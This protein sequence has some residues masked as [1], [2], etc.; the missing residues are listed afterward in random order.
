M[1]EFLVELYVYTVFTNV[2][3]KA[4]SY[5]FFGVLLER[6]G[7]CVGVPE[8]KSLIVLTHVAH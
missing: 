1:N 7:V 8:L 2:I 6:Y 5:V 4:K 3:H